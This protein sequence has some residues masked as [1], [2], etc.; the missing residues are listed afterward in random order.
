MVGEAHHVPFGCHDLFIPEWEAVGRILV[1]EYK[2]C[3]YFPI[4][5]SP[6]FVFLSLFD[7][8]SNE[9]ILSS[10]L[11]YDA[12]NQRETI[13]KIIDNFQK[14]DEDELLGVLCR[15]RCYKLVTAGSVGDNIFELTR[16]ELIQKP[17]IMVLGSDHT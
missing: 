4:F 6:A 11:L 12:P 9:I 7:E 14:C 16:Q 17:Q 15:Y 10:F 3:Q 2:G 5:L 13:K 8:V 1:R